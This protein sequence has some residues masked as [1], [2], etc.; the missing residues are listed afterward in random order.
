MN[1]TY[2]L[3]GSVTVFVPYDEISSLL[4]LCMYYCIPYTDFSPDSDG[5][6]LT[7]RYSVIPKL[8]KE[9]SSRGISIKVIRRKGLPAILE[10]Y[11]YRYGIV[12][13]CL[14]SA[15]MIFLSGRMI[16]DI[17]VTGNQ[18]ITSSEIRSLLK[19]YGFGVGT[20]IP[21]VNTDKLENRI[22]IDSEEISW[23]SV[24]I[25]GTVAEVQ[26]R[27]PEIVEGKDTQ[28]N[29]ANLVANKA[30][31][32]EEVRIFRG[33]VVANAGDY[34]E[35]GDLLV[36]GLFDSERVGFWYTRAS[37]QVLARTTNDFFIE[38]PYEYVGTKY[39]NEEY[40]DKYLNFFNFSINISKNSGKEGVL[41]DKINIVE[42]Y[43]L[44]GGLHSPIEIHTVKYMAYEQAKM[45]RS[46]AEAEELAYFELSQKLGEMAEDCVIIRKTIT[47]RVG[48]DSF[49]LYCV[50]VCVENIAVTSEFEVDMNIVGE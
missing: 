33:K 36:S 6:Q 44:P 38:V 3:L 49:S 35:K 17:R 21:S 9:A 10:K 37:G 47:P 48:E 50:V 12:L 1:I 32:I 15:I 41:Y 22:L 40:Y 29:P 46:V 43:C 8:K 14:L 19:E 23:I 18:T 45:K 27:E 31:R 2:L 13:G 25:I 4:N 24:N 26:I 28:T 39:I 11:K 16:W 20:Y 42:N 7:F 30:G 5:V 34:V